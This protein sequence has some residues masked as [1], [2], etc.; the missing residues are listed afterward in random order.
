MEAVSTTAQIVEN[1]NLL[2][3]VLIP[4]FGS[5]VVM[6]LKNNPN[7]REVVSSCCSILLLLIVLSF[8]PALPS[9]G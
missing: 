5:L 9:P 8:I 7:L 4:L 2:L 1:S 6:T 3:A